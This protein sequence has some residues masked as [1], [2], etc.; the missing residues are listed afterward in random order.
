M[1][2]RPLPRRAYTQNAEE[3]L[4]TPRW[5]TLNPHPV[6]HALWNSSA[7]FVCIPAG[8]R[9]GKTE[10][11]KRK[12]VLAAMRDNNA[13]APYGA[14]APT[15]DQAK[16]IFWEDIKALIPSW[17]I[18]DKSESELIIKLR[19]GATITV[20]GMDRPER[21]EGSPWRGLLLDEFANMRPEAWPMHVRPALSDLRCAGAWCW[22]T[23]VPEGRN[24]YYDLVLDAK[25]IRNVRNPPQLIDG[26][27]IVGEWDVFTWPSKD[28]LPPQEVLQAQQDLDELTFRQEY[29][30]E[31]VN[32]RG[33]AYYCWS[34]DVHVRPVK[35]LYNPN[36]E[37]V[38]CFDFNVD[39]GVAV[40]VQELRL[41]PPMLPAPYF[42]AIVQ[43]VKL[44]NPAAH[45]LLQTT[46]CIGEVHIPHNSTT[47]A[48]CNKLIADWGEHKGPIKLYGD[49]SGGARGSS[50]VEGS[51]W[52]LVQRTLRGHFAEGQVRSF[53]PPS[54]PAERARLN[55]VNSRLRTGSGKVQFA[56]DPTC[57]NLVRDFDGVRLLEGGSGEIDKKHDLRLTHLTDS[58]GY[59]VVK[60][61]PVRKIPGLRSTH[62]SI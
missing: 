15:R 40:V 18:R 44:P 30:G 11:G 36:G 19:H 4:L 23:G 51:D 12:L 48:V 52:D 31:F 17:M 49:A 53:V 28:I 37:L 14:F 3:N 34:P 25:G 27:E 58:V 46:A 47:V 9:S 56:V 50:R 42:P 39:P 21:I 54:N 2:P 5:T 61:F 55:A 20:G 57:R 59:Y 38:F 1:K 7:R 60:E 16:R 6:Q 26:I 24:H 33:Q 35:H 32:F 10:L 41:P 22:F 45:E 13:V 43:N 62:L 8:R 29:G